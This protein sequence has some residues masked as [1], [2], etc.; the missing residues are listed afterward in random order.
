MFKILHFADLHLDASFTRWG[1]T[2]SVARLRREELRTALKKTLAKA[3]ELGVN[4]ITVGGDLF[5]HDRVSNDTI[6]FLIGQ[7]DAVAPLPILIA[8]GNHDPLLPGSPY[9]LHN[10]PA[11]VFIF[12]G[13][14]LTPRPLDTGITIW[15]AAHNSPSF[16][17]NLFE[18]FKA[19]DEGVHLALLHGS[20][21]TCVPSG[22]EA[23]CPFSADQIAH[24]GISFALL[25]HYHRAS[26]FPGG[27]PFYGYPGSPEPLGFDEVGTHHILLAEIDS[28]G[29][30]PRLI[31]INAVDYRNLEIDTSEAT[32]IENIKQSIISTIS[33]ENLS[34]S[35]VKILLKGTLNP[36]VT[37]N[38]AR[39]IV[40]D[41][42]EACR[43]MEVEDLTTPPY[44]ID[45]LK[46]EHTARGAFVRKMIVHLETCPDEDKQIAEQA[47][48]FGLRALDNKEIDLL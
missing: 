44:D 29:V 23:H 37:I 18:H 42:H 17:R 45:A 35:L 13:T 33:R 43:F 3:D 4:C 26:L 36:D 7:F 5:E 40:D 46:D 47:L 8:P 41:C 24:S 15:G 48:S 39:S 11:N 31:P 10:W 12:S 16:R 38:L 25:G 19:P 6:N 21:V 1:M 22:K 9:T 28:N 14:E 32:S 2:P 20:D 27:Q 30:N 34:K